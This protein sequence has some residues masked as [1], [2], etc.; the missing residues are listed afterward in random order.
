VRLGRIGCV[1]GAFAGDTSASSEIWLR[2][3]NA[4]PVRFAFEDTVR[5]DAAAT[6]A[7]LRSVG[8]DV[9]LLSGDRPEAALAVAGRVG[10]GEWRAAQRP[11]DKVAYLSR[12]AEEG[13][14]VLMVGDGLNDAPALAA[15]FVSMSPSSAADISQTAADIV[16]TGKRLDPV[17]TTLR[18]ARAARRLVHQN[19]ALAIG[20]NL[21]A[22]PV[23]IAG[24]ATPL[25]AAVAM[26]TSSILVTAN[27]LRLPLLVRA[28]SRRQPAASAPAAAAEAHA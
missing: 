27:A 24:Y 14:R 22:V 12:V 19:F 7:N 2:L 15:V 10:I 9:A 8:L 4:A 28:R 5:G 3:G 11:D 17:A 23:A 18:V 1:G 13:R 25:I 21:I 6:V 20:Y 16:F 26:S